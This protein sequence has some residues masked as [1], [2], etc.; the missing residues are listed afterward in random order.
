MT[1]APV[2]PAKSTKSATGVELVFRCPCYNLLDMGCLTRFGKYL[3]F[4]SLVLL[5]IY[6]LVFTTPTFAAPNYQINYQGK[7]TDSTD[8]VV[9]DGNQC[10]QFRLMN[11][12]S[13]G[14]ELWAEEWDGATSYATTTNGLFSV[15]LGTHQSLSTVDFN[16]VIY[17][18]A[19]Y[20]PGCDDVYE[21]IFTPRKVLGAA[22]AAFEADKLDGL[23]SSQ[24]LRS[25]A[26]NATSTSSTFI[27]VNQS[28][29]GN[30]LDLQASGATIF[31]VLA[32]GNVGIA[33][34]SPYAALSVAGETV[35]EYFTATST[36]ATST[37]A[38]DVILSQFTTANN[39][40]R[41]DSSGALS[42]FNLFG[43]QNTWTATQTISTSLLLGSDADLDIGAVGTELRDI[44]I[45]KVA[46]SIRFQGSFHTQLVA[47]GGAGIDNVIVTIPQLT[48]TIALLEG[49]QTFS[50]RKTFSATTSHS[51]LL[52]TNGLVGI[53]TST[54]VSTLSIQGSLCVRDTGSCGTGG[55][56][57]YTTGG[58][59]VSIDVAENYPT[60]D[61]TI[62][63]GDIVALTDQKVAFVSP[64]DID[65]KTTP[66]REEIGGLV[67]AQAGGDRSILGIVSTRPGLLLGYDVEGAVAR[68]VALSGRVPLKVSLEGGEIRVGDRLGASSVPGV[69]KKA[70]AGEQTV[71]IA[72]E[73]FVGQ[74]GK[75]MTFV[76]LDW[77]PLSPQ[78]GQGKVY[79]LLA[80][81]SLDRL[82]ASG[83]DPIDF[84][85]R[86]LKNIR[87]L[88]S[89]TG[90]WSLD[91]EGNL[92]VEEIRASRLCLGET[93]VTEPA[94][95]YLLDNVPPSVKDAVLE[96]ATVNTGANTGGPGVPSL[97]PERVPE[98]LEIQA[99]TQKQSPA[100][101][102][103]L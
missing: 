20:D 67:K 30:I 82:L 85:G 7:L 55:G 87:S 69:G 84:Y 61:E 100:Q 42:S 83:S 40:L 79:D 80:L 41:H 101:A 76:K 78:V 15:M 19:Q 81:Q 13:S 26:T 39:F 23:D 22:P 33:T 102:S 29:S 45:D 71:G 92:V 72:L 58:N 63:A 2:V 35:A 4:W 5:C 97:V 93:C 37:F 98:P 65:G 94:L 11:A 90:K 53:A 32:N 8:Q 99:E 28:G 43:T 96:Q 95:K 17:L 27:T 49:D 6:S 47:Q 46:G 57:I 52:V 1:P 18:E 91:E 34:T 31:T 9:S 73:G 24:F 10:M 86:E 56:E 21:E 50:G 75:I 14:T 54:P 103:V 16:Q 51:G 66:T 89:A 88:A 70:E 74:T 36:T 38:G 3:V 62:E 25:D 12:A 44:F 68:P 48:G 59:V 64:L 77:G 60:L